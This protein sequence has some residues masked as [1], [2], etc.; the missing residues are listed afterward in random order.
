MVLYRRGTG[1]YGCLVETRL[2]LATKVYRRGEEM[3]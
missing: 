1:I 3:G 2:F